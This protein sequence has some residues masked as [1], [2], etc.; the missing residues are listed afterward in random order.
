[1]RQNNM[2]VWQHAQSNADKLDGLSEVTN[3]L[4]VA[5]RGSFTC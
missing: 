5:T 3:G 2:K 4:V 1:M